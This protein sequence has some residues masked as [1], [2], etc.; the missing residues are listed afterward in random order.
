[1]SEDVLFGVMVENINAPTHSLDDDYPPQMSE[2]F[3]G[4]FAVV[5]MAWRE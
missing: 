4:W 5:V 1:M 3:G 2:E